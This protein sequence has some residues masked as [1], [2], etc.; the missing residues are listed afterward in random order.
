MRRERGSVESCVRCNG[1]SVLILL[2]SATIRSASCLSRGVRPAPALAENKEDAPR[3]PSSL[4]SL[5]SSSRPLHLLT[6]HHSHISLAVLSPL[7]PALSPT[8]PAPPALKRAS[9]SARRRSSVR[10]TSD[11][12]RRASGGGG[13]GAEC[14]L[15]AAGASAD[16]DGDD[17]GKGPDAALALEKRGT[18]RSCTGER[19]ER[20]A[21]DAART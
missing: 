21:S 15:L 13:A 12:T 4:S 17:E 3:P 10:C 1:V 2:D 20:N 11:S 5:T 19:A 9:R 18:L 16:G 14:A 7:S 6:A 8:A